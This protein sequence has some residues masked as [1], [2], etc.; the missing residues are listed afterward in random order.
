VP[1]V[2]ARDVYRH[3]KIQRVSIWHGVV[4]RALLPMLTRR[5]KAFAESYRMES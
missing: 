5:F 1:A 4:A 3:H 2:K